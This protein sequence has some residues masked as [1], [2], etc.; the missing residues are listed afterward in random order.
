M[1]KELLIQEDITA[2]TVFDGDI[3]ALL[4]EIKGKATSMAFDVNT[5]K[6]RKEIASMG[7]KV[8]STKT[9]LDGL[10][11]GLVDGW[12]AQAKVIDSKRKQIR[13][14]L[15]ELKQAVRLPLTEWEQ[16]EQ[17]RISKCT[18]F[19]DAIKN[20][21]QLTDQYGTLFN[22]EELKD[23][24]AYIHRQ[25][26]DERLA[27]FETEAHRLKAEGIAKLNDGIVMAEGKE[28]EAAELER[29]RLEKEEQNRIDYEQKLKDKAAAEAK[30]HA[31]L[32]AKAEIEAAEKRLKEQQLR[33]EQEKQ[34]AIK[35][36]QQRIENQRLQT[37][38]EAKA[39]EANKEHKRT[40]NNQAM[41]GF[42]AGGF[43]E[44]DA[45]KA[46]GLIAKGNIAHIKINY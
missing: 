29:L 17:D 43:S 14:G 24:L 42:I 11:K 23:N 26:V 7:H 2:A 21:S 10:G 38:A 13:D 34:E 32:Q 19:L 22:S 6:G 9:L 46:V 3:D 8:A 27:E 41:Q 45:K 35:A 25:A 39:R 37:E 30:Y 20:K 36:E 15:D 1:S 33:A 44:S 18:A 40:I 12:K 28:K 16:A 5:S 4:L 31:E